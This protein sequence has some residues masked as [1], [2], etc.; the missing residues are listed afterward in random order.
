MRLFSHFLH[1]CARFKRVEQLARRL[2]EI[3][4]TIKLIDYNFC[5]IIFSKNEIGWV[6]GERETQ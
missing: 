3:K 2:Y 5:I 1:T 6:M 4:I